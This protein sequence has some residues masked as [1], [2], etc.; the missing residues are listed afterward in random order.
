MAALSPTRCLP[1]SHT[2]H[3]Q[4]P[5]AHRRPR[6]RPTPTTLQPV[7]NPKTSGATSNSGGPA[8][9]RL[10]TKS[11]RGGSPVPQAQPARRMPRRTLRSG[12][13]SGSRC[14][15]TQTTDKGRCA[16]SPDAPI[17]PAGNTDHDGA[18]TKACRR[19]QGHPAER[20]RLCG[21]NGQAAVRKATARPPLTLLGVTAS[22]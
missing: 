11:E 19:S 2:Q 18:Q 20:L 3:N 10:P 9:L 13:L 22:A 12:P 15:P 17:L 14:P 16:E 6:R 1:D 5:T 4:P 8:R 7:A 21:H